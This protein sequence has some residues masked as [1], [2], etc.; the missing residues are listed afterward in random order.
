MHNLAYRAFDGMRPPGV[1]VPF[2]DSIA[3]TGRCS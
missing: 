3:Q 2:E 1:A